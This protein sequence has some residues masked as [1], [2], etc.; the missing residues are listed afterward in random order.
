MDATMLLRN[1][2]ATRRAI[3]L[4]NRRSEPARAGGD[5]IGRHSQNLGEFV[6]RRRDLNSH[7]N[8]IF[9][10]QFAGSRRQIGMETVLS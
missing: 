9:L 1:I 10:R 6:G 2:A 7:Q 5:G 8:D 3:L 4:D